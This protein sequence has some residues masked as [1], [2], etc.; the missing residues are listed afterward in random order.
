MGKGKIWTS[1]ESLHLAEAFREVSEDHDM[2]RVRG[3]NQTAEV[4]TARVLVKFNSR[5]TEDALDGSYSMRTASA[6]WNQ[7]KDT[8][9]AKVSKFNKC[10]TIVYSAKP[11]GVRIPRK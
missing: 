10:L 11:S 5:A 9:K 8:L 6:I 4:F 1:E 7:W 3:T 2:S